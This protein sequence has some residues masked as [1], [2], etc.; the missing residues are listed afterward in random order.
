VA[1]DR[2]R[3][4]HQRLRPRGTAHGAAR[5]KPLQA[6]QRAACQAVIGRCS[7]SGSPGRACM[8]HTWWT[9]YYSSVLHPTRTPR[10]T[11]W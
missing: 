9:P 4:T 5:W 8:Q 1:R 10:T 7:C 6:L 11:V 2:G 3:D